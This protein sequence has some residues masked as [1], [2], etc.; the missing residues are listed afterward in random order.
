MRRYDHLAMTRRSLLL[1][2]GAAGALTLGSLPGAA[3]TDARLSAGR[4]KGKVTW[5][6]SVSPDELRKELVDDFKKKTGIDVTIYYGGTG[7][8]F[9]RLN[10]ERKT[11]S[12][13]VDV[14]TLGDVDLVEELKKTSALRPYA[15][16]NAS[17]VQSAFKG[18]DDQWVGICFWGMTLEYN[19]Q[20][21]TKEAAPRTWAEIADPKWR[22]KVV[23]SDPARSAGGL[24]M[25]KAM[26]KEQGWDWV[27]KLM[28]N[29]PLVIA[30]APGIDQA[31]ANGERQ[32][33]TGVTSFVSETMKS[34]APVATSGD[35][36][37][38]S[39]LTASIIKEA[40]NPEGAELLVDYLTSK[41]AGELFRKY[42]WF[43]SRG[44]VA[45]PFG[46]PAASQLKILYPE[47]E[48][49]MTRQEILDKYNAIVA[50]AKKS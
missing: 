3:Q 22:G 49:P 30:I 1:A 16:A 20:A 45:G 48:L 31:V 14:V 33:G 36:L 28:K 43:S 8:V 38:T 42:G 15:S 4:A 2:A 44:D 26:V 25:L 24:L 10:T 39:P 11:Q 21:V 32:V 34:K 47:V 5:Y 46:F 23:I 37:L 27:E 50:T 9:S 7:Q 29:D 19:T 41:D 18:K 6:T 13:A 40:P 17:A 35:V 12:Y